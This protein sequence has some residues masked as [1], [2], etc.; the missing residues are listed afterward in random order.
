MVAAATALGRSVKW[1]EDRNEHLL[2]GGQARDERVDVDAA[3]AHD[4]TLLGLARPPDDGPGRLPGLPVGRRRCS[5][6]SSAT[7]MPGPYRLPA[8]RFDTTRRGHQQGDLRRLPRARGRSRRGCASGCSTSLARRAR[9]RPRRDPAA[10]PDRRRELPTT[11]ITG[12][13]LDVRMSARATFE[14]GDGASPTSTEWP[15]Q[16]AAARAEGRLLGLGF[17]TFI[18]A[19]PGPPDFGAH[20]MGGVGSALGE[21]A[22]AAGARGRRHGCGA[23]AADAA[24]P[25]PRDD[26]RPGRGR[27]AGRAGRAGAGPLRRHRA[28]ARSAWSA[29]AAA[30]RRPWPA[31]RSRSATRELRERIL[32]V[33]A[34]LLEA[35]PRRPRGRA[36]AACTW[37]GCRPSRRRSP[38]SPP[39]PD[40]PRR[41]PPPGESIAHH[42]RVGRRRGRVGPGHARVLGRGRPEHRQRARS[43]GTSWSRTA[44]RSSTRWSSTARSRAAWRRASAR[45][46]TRR[47]ST[48][49]TPSS[50]PARSWT[51]CSR[52]RRRSPTSRSTTSRR[53]ATSRPTTAASARAA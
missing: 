49:P 53:R 5:P 38:T 17:A 1:I 34:E 28:H 37:P 30:A 45:C 16:Q 35:A 32:D 36:T 6:A 44:A 7:M 24:R 15:A 19:A 26:A 11:M 14:T 46:S 43:R 50:R 39:P 52:P 3:F 40:A 4:G 21:R 20:V 8:F 47:R 12:P 29:P 27:R 51:T 33:A 2:V 22:G 23:H 25:G 18:E 9:H 41:R 31:A 10:Q 13:T 48:T 42:R